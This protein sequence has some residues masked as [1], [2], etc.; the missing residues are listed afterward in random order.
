MYLKLKTK[1]YLAKSYQEIKKL[2]TKSDRI[3]SRWNAA[4]NWR[5]IHCNNLADVLGTNNVL[6]SKIYGRVAWWLATCTR[7]LKVP[8]L[9]PAASYVQRWAL[10]SNRPANV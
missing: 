9:S 6:R 5:L 1:R 7:K 4:I 2:E 10:C 3:I 8:G